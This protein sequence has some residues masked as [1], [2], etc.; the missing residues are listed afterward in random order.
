MVIFIFMGVMGCGK[1][2][3]G[4]IISEKINFQFFDAG[5]INKNNDIL[6]K[7]KIIFIQKKIKKK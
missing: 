2:T 5:N 3:I 1:T 4:K 7:R 6:M